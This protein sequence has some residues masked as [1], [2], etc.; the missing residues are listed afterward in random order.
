MPERFRQ[1]HR[2]HQRGYVDQ[3]TKKEMGGHLSTIAVRAN[4]EEFR[5]AVSLNGARTNDGLFVTCIIRDMT[6]NE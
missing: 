5:V 4:G 6:L 2:T 3:P 1:P